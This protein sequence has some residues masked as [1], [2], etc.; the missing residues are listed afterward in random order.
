MAGITPLP[1]L[2]CPPLAPPGVLTWG[3]KLT[4]EYQLFISD[5]NSSQNLTADSSTDR[6]DLQWN[7]NRIKS[8]CW[9][10]DLL[11][12]ISGLVTLFIIH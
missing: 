1:S 6:Q 12:I 3:L 4:L 9:N 7:I 10:N 11:Q 5:L 2:P 8:I